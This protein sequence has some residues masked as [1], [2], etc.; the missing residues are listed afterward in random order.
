MLI[1]SI[2]EL[3]KIN[4][5]IDLLDRIP[6]SWS[7]NNPKLVV[8]INGMA[9]NIYSNTYN[10]LLRSYSYKLYKDC[11]NILYEVTKDENYK[12]VV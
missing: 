5:R 3:D 7:P 8:L 6:V 4:T 2:K 1:Y 12:K 10:R 9:Y 11:Y